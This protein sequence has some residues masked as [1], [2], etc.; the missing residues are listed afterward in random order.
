MK[1]ISTTPLALAAIGC[2]NA[3][4]YAYNG[5]VNHEMKEDRGNLWGSK[6]FEEGHRRAQ[7]T[8]RQR[9]M[10]EEIPRDSVRRRT[11]GE[12]PVPPNMGE[13]DDAVFGQDREQQSHY[14]VRTFRPEYRQPHVF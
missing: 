14:E 12:I 10:E 6:R 3:K 7:E 5:F 2:A 13:D 8:T 9:R 4:H 1:L 11:E